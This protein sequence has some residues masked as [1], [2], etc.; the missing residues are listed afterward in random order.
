LGDWDCYALSSAWLS[1]STFGTPQ[2][3]PAPSPMI[4]RIAATHF[5]EIKIS[6]TPA[7][8]SEPENK[9]RHRCTRSPRKL[10]ALKNWVFTCSIYFSGA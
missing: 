7:P 9:N 4:T 10:Y 1:S 3:T 8:P 2:T 6:F 5:F